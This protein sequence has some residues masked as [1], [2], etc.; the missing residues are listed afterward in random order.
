MRRSPRSLSSWVSHGVLGLG[1][2]DDFATVEAARENLII[3]PI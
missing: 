2:T 1:T 3:G